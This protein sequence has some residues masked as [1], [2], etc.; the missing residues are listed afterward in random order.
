[1]ADLP[2]VDF[3]KRLDEGVDPRVPGGVGQGGQIVGVADLDQGLA[4][5]RVQGLHRVAP[6]GHFLGVIGVADDEA[7]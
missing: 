2:G 3:G 1:M 6:T 5:L 4:A 7:G